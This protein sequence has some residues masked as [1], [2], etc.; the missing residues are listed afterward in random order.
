MKWTIRNGPRFMLTPTCWMNADGG[1]F[2]KLPPQQSGMRPWTLQ[3][4]SRHDRAG[5]IKHHNKSICSPENNM[6]SI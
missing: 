4:T 2:P 5:D 1:L 6:I 3:R